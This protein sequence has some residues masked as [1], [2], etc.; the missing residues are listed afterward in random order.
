MPTT[1]GSTSP[2]FPVHSM[3][4]MQN[5]YKIYLSSYNQNQN[6]IKTEK[7]WFSVRMFLSSWNIEFNDWK[8][9]KIQIEDSF[10]TLFLLAITLS[11]MVYKHFS[12]KNGNNIKQS[13]FIYFTLSQVFWFAL[14]FLEIIHS[15]HIACPLLS[16]KLIYL[17]I[18][19]LPSKTKAFCES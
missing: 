9:D 18:R 1:H 14:L 17:L 2:S 19:P 13:H 12:N 8:E 5:S 11:F 10:F 6:S 16:L 4:C 15:F 7:Y 3:G